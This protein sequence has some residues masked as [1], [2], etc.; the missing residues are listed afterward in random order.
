MEEGYLGDGEAAEG[1]GGAGDALAS[2]LVDLVD[3][4]DAVHLQARLG[5][6]GGRVAGDEEGRGDDWAARSAARSSVGW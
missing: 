3:H 4:L 1:E 5:G 2:D 6:E